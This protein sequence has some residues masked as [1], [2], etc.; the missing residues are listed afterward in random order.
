M[1]CAHARARRPGDEAAAKKM[2]LALYKDITKTWPTTDFD[3][4]ESKPITNAV[5]EKIRAA[6]IKF[7]YKRGAA[8]KHEAGRAGA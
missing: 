2:A 1:I 6:Q 8:A 4:T 3:R 5:Y 7:A